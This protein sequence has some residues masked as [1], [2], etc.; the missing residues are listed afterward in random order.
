M[1]KFAGF[2][3]ASAVA[4]LLSAPA[5]AKADTLTDI[6]ACSVNV[7]YSRNNSV[8][9]T[10]VKDFQVS[11]NTPY[12]D[13]FSNTLRFRFFDANMTVEDGLPVVHIAFDADVDTFNAVA[14]GAEL[15]VRDTSKG[16]TTQGNSGFFTSVPGAAGSHRTIYTLTCQKA[17]N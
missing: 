8:R 15:R 7:E 17:Q 12:S 9:L 16:E 5:V 13:D 3:A 4:A 1:L 11:L 14:F 6:M 10:Y 2:L